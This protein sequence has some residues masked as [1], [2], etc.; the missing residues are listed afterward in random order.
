METITAVCES[1]RA[2]Y[3]L[4]NARLSAARS[5]NW[6]SRLESSRESV[7]QLRGALTV[8]TGN[9]TGLLVVLR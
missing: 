6:D 4:V 3:D 7:Y 2:A 1:G 8:A 5:G 9:G